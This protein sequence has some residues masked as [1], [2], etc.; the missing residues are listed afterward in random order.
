MH[1]CPNMAAADRSRKCAERLSDLGC[2]RIGSPQ[3]AHHA[4]F[5]RQCSPV[6]AAA[7]NAPPNGSVW[8]HFHGNLRPGVPFMHYGLRWISSLTTE[9]TA[10]C[11]TGGDLRD[12]VNITKEH[13]SSASQMK[14]NARLSASKCGFV[15]IRDFRWNVPAHR[16]SPVVEPRSQCDVC[17]NS[18]TALRPAQLPFPL[19]IT[20]SE[21]LPTPH[22]LPK[23]LPHRRPIA[24]LRV[25]WKW[26]ILGQ[27]RGDVPTSFSGRPRVLY[28]RREASEIT[29]CSLREYGGVCLRE[30]A[31]VSRRGWL[32]NTNT[33]EWSSP[34][35]G[36][37]RFRLPFKIRPWYDVHDQF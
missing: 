25:R 33:G 19:F 22:S 6:A 28:H 7:A 10:I 9:H 21:V 26:M 3:T 34:E 11:I 20:A 5:P 2:A 29:A 35:H 12:R 30:A 36:T 13:I 14:W 23:L 16:L 31:G 17:V 24:A 1:S 8:L 18:F 37:R 27:K 32:A 4:R 15:H